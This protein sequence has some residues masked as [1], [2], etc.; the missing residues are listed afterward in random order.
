MPNPGVECRLA[1]DGEL[2]LRSR[3]NMLGYFKDPDGTARMLDQDGFLH[4]GD[5]GEVDKEGFLRV[6]G[7]A[8][9]VFTTRA[10]KVI[11][12]GPIERLL[13]ASTLIEQSCVLG[14]NLPQPIALVQ[15][16]EAES[17]AQEPT[18]DERLSRILNDS[19]KRLP[20][21]QQ[22][23]CLVVMRDK[24][25]VNNGFITPTLKLKRHVVAAT[26]QDQLEM[27][28]VSGKRVLWQETPASD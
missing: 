24:W 8:R 28:S 9:D 27:W 26:Y 16:H 23:A 21:H 13:D 19:N 6:I 10:G 2:L 5:L 3:A 15:L 25:N 18:I 12:P 22:L 7:R 20:Q 11:R 17:D 4:T 1:D 14:E